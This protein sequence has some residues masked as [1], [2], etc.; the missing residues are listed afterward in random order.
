MAT[1]SSAQAVFA[2]GRLIASHAYRQIARGGGGGSAIKESVEHIRSFAVIWRASASIC[3]G[4][5]PCRSTTS[6]TG[7][8]ARRTTSIAIRGWS[9][10]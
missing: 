8:R 10:R 1:T 6:S 4:M 5:A 2:D 3:A 7:H 9:S